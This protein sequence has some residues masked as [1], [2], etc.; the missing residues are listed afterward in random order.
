MPRHERC[1]T[2]ALANA[3]LLLRCSHAAG[4]QVRAR[5][6][7]C[8]HAIHVAA[9]AGL[10][11]QHERRRNH[12]ASPEP[13]SSRLHHPCHARAHTQFLGSVY[14][15]KASSSVK[16]YQ[17][18]EHALYLGNTLFATGMWLFSTGFALIV[19]DTRSTIVALAKL[20]GVRARS[21]RDISGAHAR[22]PV[23]HRSLCR[24]MTAH[25]TCCSST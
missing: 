25:C 22:C 3:E 9:L 5:R 8:H 6:G 14:Y 7:A 1:H 17:N 2:R 4:A 18:D 23:F 13:L 10:F 20:K 19:H 12:G 16:V 24:C 11:P 21:A 15:L